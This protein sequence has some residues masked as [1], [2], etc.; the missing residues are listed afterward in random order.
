MYRALLFP[1]LPS[2]SLSA[3]ASPSPSLSPVYASGARLHLHRHDWGSLH[4]PQRSSTPNNKKQN[5]KTRTCARTGAMRV[6]TCVCLHAGGRPGCRRSRGTSLYLHRLLC[7]QSDLRC[8][9]KDRRRGE[10][11]WREGVEVVGMF[12]S[13]E[14]IIPSFRAPF[15]AV[16]SNTHPHVL[17]CILTFFPF[18]TLPPFSLDPAPIPS[19]ALIKRLEKKRANELD[20]TNKTSRSLPGSNKGEMHD[21]RWA[22]LARKMLAGACSL[23][24]CAPSLLPHSQTTHAVCVRVL[25]TIP[26]CISCMPNELSQSLSLEPTH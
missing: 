2:L 14:D 12:H 21:E 22:N 5:D 7:H 9:T 20:Q 4:Q 19:S 16:L 18:P 26:R 10:G 3:S 1:P 17:A 13:S 24:A 23:D 6:L 15:A 8:A 25:A 11:K